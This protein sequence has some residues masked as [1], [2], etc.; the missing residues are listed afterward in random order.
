MATATKTK[1]QKKKE[2]EAI[3]AASAEKQRDEE[4][5]PVVEMTVDG[6]ECRISLDDLDYGE[7]AEME[8]FY[9]KPMGAITVGEMSGAR[10]DIILAYLARRRVDPT[11]T[12]AKTKA[13]KPSDIEVR[14]ERPTSP[15]ENSGDQS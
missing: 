3:K 1:Q 6:I 8:F 4:T 11:W 12:L 7:Q 14:E 10:G 2:A 9:G 13:L 15:R 5:A